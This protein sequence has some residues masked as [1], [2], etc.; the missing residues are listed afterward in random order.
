M[1]WD[2]SSFKANSSYIDQKHMDLTDKNRNND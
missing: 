1:P 2:M